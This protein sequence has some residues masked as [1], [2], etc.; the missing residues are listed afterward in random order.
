MGGAGGGD[1]LRRH[2]RF[3]PPR[4]RRGNAGRRNGLSLKRTCRRNKRGV[5][6]AGPRSDAKRAR[7]GHEPDA[8]G[9]FW[10]PA[11]AVQA[12]FATACDRPESARRPLQRRELRPCGRRSRTQER[13]SIPAELPARPET[14]RSCDRAYRPCRTTHPD[15]PCYRPACRTADALRRRTIRPPR[16]GW[17]TR[18]NPRLP[19]AAPASG[20]ACD[21]RI[22]RRAPEGVEV[23]PEVLCSLSATA[24]PLRDRCPPGL[25]GRRRRAAILRTSRT[26]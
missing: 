21:R 17:P 8:S 20:E 13:P 11:A 10:P 22:E 6:R 24:D 2:H 25:C 14:A 26:S 4:S 18:V 16:P 1:S 12:S 7:A 15:S 23:V 9:G 5:R 3:R 19:P